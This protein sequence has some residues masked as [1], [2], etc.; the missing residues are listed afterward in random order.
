MLAGLRG[1]AFDPLD[2]RRGV[3]DRRVLLV[4]TAAPAAAPGR[5]D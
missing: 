2:H 5:I 4:Y 3:E 1:E